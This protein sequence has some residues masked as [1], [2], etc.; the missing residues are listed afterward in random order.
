MTAPVWDGEGEDPWLP[1]RIQSILDAAAAERS[2]YA[3]VWDVLS[4]WLVTTSRRM[5]RGPTLDPSVIFSREPAWQAGVDRIIEQGILP[6]MGLAYG[7]LFGP[8][9]DWRDSAP[10]LAYLAT[11][12]NRMSNTPSEVFDLV[13]GQVASGVTLGESVPDIAERVDNVLSIT[14]TQRWP[15]RAVVIARTETLGAL[16]GSRFDAFAAF[17]EASDAEMER[18]WLSTIDT[19]TRPSHVLADGQRAGVNDPFTVGG[20]SLMFPGDPSGPAQ[21]V[22]QCR[23]TT[24]L[25]NKGEKVDLSRRQLKRR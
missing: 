9:F 25:L 8:E 6:A 4:S 3:I 15:N 1:A 21:E 24:L 22:I 23:C 16:N 5:M 2:I 10:T 12:R 17:A 19:R 11:V 13:S 14:D 20:F 18:M 7:Q